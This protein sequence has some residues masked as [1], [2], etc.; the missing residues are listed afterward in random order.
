MFDASCVCAGTVFGDMSV[1]EGL[2]DKVSIYSYALSQI[3]V[4]VLY[5][6]VMTG[7]S[8]CMEQIKHDYNGDCRVDILD[9]AMFA[10]DW[11]ECNLVP[12]CMP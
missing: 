8:I 12:E 7:E 2:L 9:F 5:T 6:D 3:D 10:A 11:L 4:A 1:Y